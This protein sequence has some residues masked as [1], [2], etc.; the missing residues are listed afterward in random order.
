MHPI[1]IIVFIC[2]VVG[3]VIMI[4]GIDEMRKGR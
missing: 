3:G 2:V 4:K 1:T